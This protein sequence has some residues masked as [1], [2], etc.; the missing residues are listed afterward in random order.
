MQARSA[1]WPRQ[2]P[3]EGD[4]RGAGRKGSSSLDRVGAKLYRTV[5][6]DTA[7]AAI[8][9]ISSLKELGPRYR[10]WLVD[11]WGV[12]HNGHRAY[13][14][15]LI[16]TR[17]FREEGGI[18]VLLSNSPRPSAAVQQQ[19]RDLGIPYDAYDA[20]V[21]S[22]DLTRYELAKH[23]GARVFHLGPGRDQPIFDGVDVR[24]VG[25]DDAE[26]IVC[27]GLF[28]DETE[29]PDHYQ[30][31]LK[32][33]ADRRLPMICANPDIQVERGPKL[34]WCAGALAALYEKLGG[35]VVWAG[36]PYA[37]IYRLA[38]ETV[39]G[40]AGGNVP[41]EQILAIGDGI[42]TDIKGAAGA[43]ID[44][45]FV[46]SGLHLPD[47]PPGAPLDGAKLAPLFSG[48]RPIAAMR[49]LAW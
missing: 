8:P 28:D 24:L 17:A 20:T 42:N 39:T 3:R 15:S 2:P 1:R 40:L 34:I 35:K 13:L 49:A 30:S 10:V 22:G 7:T 12:M 9:I 37:P 29:T 21:T 32:A 11:I 4:Y 41:K 14:R 5:M 27:S 47:A 23:Q 48:K 44:A 45:V 26:L 46:V 25:R 18:V 36:K 31:M 16:S 19:M 33:F 38:F 6:A 43:G